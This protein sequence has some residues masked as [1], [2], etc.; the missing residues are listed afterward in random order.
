MR[1]LVLRLS[2]LALA[3]AVVATTSVGCSGSKKSSSRLKGAGSSFVAHAMEEWTREFE[4]KGVSVDYASVGSGN[5]VS[6]MIGKK[7]DFACTDA[8]MN[9]KQLK[10]AEGEDKVVHIP[11]V[12][13]AVVIIY[14][15]DVDKPIQFDGPILA[16]IYLGNI[17]R[18]DD[19]RLKKLN[20]DIKKLPDLPISVVHR[21]EASG[22]SYIFTDY[23]SSVSPAWKQ[24][25][26]VGTN[27]TW[28]AGQQGAQK[29]PGVTEAVK[30]K[31]G[32]IGYVELSYALQ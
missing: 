31:E 6:N 8:P 30:G 13:G 28:Q 32:A 14:N 1:K 27:P 10:E 4:S 23:L 18:W 15:L 19:D 21:A 7:V 16:D 24:K 5:G 20:P 11:L 12:M 2:S 22:T 17:K 25:V 26:G 9:D 29:S 3:F